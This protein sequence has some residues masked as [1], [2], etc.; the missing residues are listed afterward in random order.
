MQQKREERQG[1]FGWREGGWEGN[2]GEEGSDLHSPSLPPAP[3]TPTKPIPRPRPCPHLTPE[4]ER[5]GR[6]Q[7]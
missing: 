6:Y 2:M 4:E 1:K 5:P 7:S 3:Q